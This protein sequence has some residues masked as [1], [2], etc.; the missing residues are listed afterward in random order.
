MSSRLALVV[1][2]CLGSPVAAEC[3]ELRIIKREPFAGGKEF[4]DTGA[5]ERIIGVAK[6]AIDPANKRNAVIVD[7]D[8][9]PRNK[10]GKVEFISDVFILAPKD[11]AKGNGAILYDVNN[12]GNKLALAFFN[13]APGTND[14]L[15]VEH[16]GNGFLLRCGYALV[17]CGWIGE[18]LPGNHRLLMQAPIATENGKPITGVVRF[19][20]GTDTA[21]ESLPLSRRDGHGSYNP[22]EKGEKEG[23]LT[24]RMRETDARVVIPREQWSLVRIPPEKVA[25]GVPGTLSQIRLKVSGGFRPGYLYELICECENPIVQ[26]CGFASVRDLV[27][28][29]RYDG[30]DKNPL[31]AKGKSPI[32]RTFGFGISQSGRFLRHFLFEGFNADEK[33]RKVFDGLM[34]HVAGGGLGFF[35]HRFAQPTR[36]NGQQEEHL[37]PGD[38]FP[39][40]YGTSA[41]KGS[42]EGNGEKVAD[43]IL[44]KYTHPKMKLFRPKVIHTQSAAE[45]W[46]RSGSLVHTE[47]DGS[48]DSEPPDSVRI[49]AFGGTQ[50]G[51]AADPPKPGSGDNLPNPGNFKPLSR[52]LLVALD[53]WAKSGVLPPQSRVPEIRAETLVEPAEYRKLFPALPGVRV[54][55]VIQQPPI[56]DRGDEFLTKGRIT[57]E[58]PRILGHYKVLVPKPDADGNDLGCLLPPEVAVPLA[59]YTGWNLRKK[60]VGAEGMLLS[61]QG[62]YIPFPKT[63]AERKATGDPRK[64][65]EERYDNFAEYEKQFRAVCEKYVKE[66]Y[67]LQEDADKLIASREKLRGLFPKK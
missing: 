19:E 41:A 9:A 57:I 26:G 42:D 52:A 25:E 46:H 23:V 7:L 11:P 44:Q 2:F 63:A 18:L 10:D 4:G 28:F 61:L 17:W 30:S 50:H 3:I 21:A 20:T 36:H 48:D 37:Y 29:L 53:E 38:M 51:P 35:N 59:T 56:V 32:D 45:Y 39:F 22:T 64:S 60:E 24:W 67:L 40:T 65:I 6:F 47:P 54:S 27:S 5:Y 15:T 13:D 55:D 16:A 43:G 14:P 34:P 31:A 62:S 66:R 8:K 12:R 33:D 49:V 1:L 58:P